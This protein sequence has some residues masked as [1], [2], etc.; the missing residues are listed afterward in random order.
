MNTSLAGLSISNLE[1]NTVPRCTK[2]PFPH[3]TMPG[4]SSATSQGVVEKPLPGRWDEVTAPGAA[5]GGPVD[6]GSAE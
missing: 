4:T 3:S 5:G 2:C 6:P 1:L